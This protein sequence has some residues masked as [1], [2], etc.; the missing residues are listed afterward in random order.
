MYSET[1]YMPR[2]VQSLADDL[3]TC[4][5]ALRK[6][7]QARSRADH[8]CL[9]LCR[10]GES[11]TFET[12]LPGPDGLSQLVVLPLID[13]LVVET[14]ARNGVEVSVFRRGETGSLAALPPF[15]QLYLPIVLGAFDAA[16][17][18]R[19]FVTGHVTQTLD[20]RIACRNGHSQ[21]IGNDAD[22]HHA[23]RLRALHDAVLVGAR[24]VEQDDPQLTVRHVAGDDPRRVVL[25]GSASTL[26]SPTRFRVFHN[27]RSTLM[28]NPRGA[29]SL[30]DGAG[31]GVDVVELE[32]GHDGWISGADVCRALVR[33]GC[34]SVFV[35]GGGSTLSR[36]LT[37]DCL[38][39]LHVHVAPMIL[40]SG[41]PSFSLP[42]VATVQEGRR[43]RAR[44][45]TMD[46]ELL[47]ECRP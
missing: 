45:F 25:N 16:Q 41:I 17:Q 11:W 10:R 47:I 15:L 14:P 27:G 28:C 6:F 9:Y 33:R 1:A 34:H 39:L 3:W 24:T 32:A 46:G 12:A 31:D 40:G 29:A 8:S 5:L 13:N 19:V 4:V 37:N 44:H 20:G 36:F 7:L 38:D 2:A 35:E 23:H 18:G 42:E 21:W 43:L 22:L 26:H 30:V